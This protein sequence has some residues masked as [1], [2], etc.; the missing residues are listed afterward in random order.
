MKITDILS[1]ITK[2][3]GLNDDEKKALSE[4]DLQKV[5]DSAAAAARKEAQTKADEIA[6]AKADLEKRAT[7]LESALKQKDDAGKTDLEKSQAQ[8]AEFAKKLQSME[9]SLAAKDKEA[10]QLKRSH[11]LAEI[12]RK[13]GVQFADGLDH[14]MLEESFSRAFDGINDLADETVIK[15]KVDT[16]ATLNKAAILDTSGHGSGS[17]NPNA[18]AAP[19]AVAKTAEERQEQLRK[20]GIL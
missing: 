17:R 1:K 13:M 6:K 10:S 4:F 8:I 2:G 18:P 15:T 12:R 3:E 14:G 19:R 16:W 20:E 7:E 11:S 9:Q 5:I